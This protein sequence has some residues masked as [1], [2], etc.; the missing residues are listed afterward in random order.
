MSPLL[1]TAIEAAKIGGARAES[2][3]NKPLEVRYKVDK[4]PVSIA[5]IATEKA[6]KTYISTQYHNARFLAEE[7]DS[8]IKD[9]DFWVI[10]PI[11]GTSKLVS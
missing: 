10:D 5:D 3:F 11:D 8:T 1:A 6:I 9:K 7:T 2:F 4:S